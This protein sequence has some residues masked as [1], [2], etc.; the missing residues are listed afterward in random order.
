MLENE[1]K[2]KTIK[3]IINISWLIGFDSNEWIWI[4]LSRLIVI[5]IHTVTQTIS[6][7]LILL[8]LL[9]SSLSLIILFNLSN[10]RY[11]LSLSLLTSFFLGVYW[12]NEFR[13]VFLMNLVSSIVA[14]FWNRHESC[15]F[16]GN[17][18]LNNFHIFLCHDKENKVTLLIFVH[19]WNNDDKIIAMKLSILIRISCYKTSMMTDI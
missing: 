13:H 7:L 14:R 12:K 16:V 9:S 6:K 10:A 3:N 11:S 5:H 19:L 17:E 4:C 18:V 1:N 15:N 2:M 8:L